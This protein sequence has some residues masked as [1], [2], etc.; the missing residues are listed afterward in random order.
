MNMGIRKLLIATK[1]FYLGL[2]RVP[3]AEVLAL[4]ELE[5]AKRSLLEM[6]TAKDYSGRMV[7]YNMDRIR[8]L[9]IYLNK[10]MESKAENKGEAQ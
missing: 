4:R 2:F 3:S 7:E 5:E 10:A 1:G 6:Q 9:T 8:R